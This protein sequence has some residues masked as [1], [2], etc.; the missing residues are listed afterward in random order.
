M[1]VDTTVT[2]DTREYI[3]LDAV[4]PADE[5]EQEP[6]DLQRALMEELSRLLSAPMPWVG[7]GRMR[8]AL[9]TTAGKRLGFLPT[10]LGVEKW[11][12]SLQEQFGAAALLKAKKDLGEPRTGW[13]ADI[14]TTKGGIL[15]VTSA[16]V[17][18]AW[19]GTTLEELVKEAAYLVEEEKG[20]WPCVN[21]KAA[22]FGK[23]T[24][25]RWRRATDD[26]SHRFACPECGS[27]YIRPHPLA[28]NDDG[29]FEFRIV[30]DPGYWAVDL[31]REWMNPEHTYAS[32]ERLYGILARAT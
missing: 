32:L 14:L 26:I 29:T 3:A 5:L 18:A 1:L 4:P 21:K 30:R 20:P 9:I 27:S 8:T 24:I 12:A 25:K 17:V 10:K 16:I 13:L 28:T 11:A 23:L 2:R 6:D 22:C 19:A 31:E 7:R 15:P